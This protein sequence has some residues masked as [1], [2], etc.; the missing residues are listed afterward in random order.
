MPKRK[1]FECEQNFDPGFVFDMFQ[2]L[3]IGLKQMLFEEPYG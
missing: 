3:K 2:Y 1:S